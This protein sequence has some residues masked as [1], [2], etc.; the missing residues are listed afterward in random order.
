MVGKD[1]L[2]A[3]QLYPEPEDTCCVNVALSC[4]GVQRQT[5]Q[6]CSCVLELGCCVFLW[7]AGALVVVAMLRNRTDALSALSTC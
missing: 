3:L 2:Q 4:F 1:W 5:V 7:C 6:P